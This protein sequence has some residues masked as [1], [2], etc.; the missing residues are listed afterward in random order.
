MAHRPNI[1]P[2]TINFL[3]LAS[4]MF[5]VMRPN[6]VSKHELQHKMTVPIYD[7]SKQTITNAVCYPCSESRS[8]R[9][10]TMTGLNTEK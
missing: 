5:T 2:E 10:G 9:F 8:F 7:D 1:T 3:R 6:I 4:K